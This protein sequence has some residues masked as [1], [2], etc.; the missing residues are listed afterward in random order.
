MALTSEKSQTIIDVTFKFEEQ[1][2]S[3]KKQI[4][5]L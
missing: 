1:V 5:E 2:S 4:E 3:Q